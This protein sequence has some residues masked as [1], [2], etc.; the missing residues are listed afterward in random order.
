MVTDQS[1]HNNLYQ[2]RLGW[3]PTRLAHLDASVVYPTFVYSV[4]NFVPKCAKRFA[5][6]NAMCEKVDACLP[7]FV[8]WPLALSSPVKAIPTSRPSRRQSRGTIRPRPFSDCI[9]DFSRSDLSPPQSK[10]KGPVC[11]CQIA[12]HS[13]PRKCRVG[14]DLL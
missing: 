13:R 2:P 9:R 7:R 1:N 8:F 12:A 14:P 4:T 11:V 5:Q 10:S 6:C 3:H